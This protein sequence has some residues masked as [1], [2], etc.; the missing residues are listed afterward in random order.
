[1]RVPSSDNRSAVVSDFCPKKHRRQVHFFFFFAL[2]THA[3]AD[4]GD[5]GPFHSV[6]WSVDWSHCPANA[7]A[8]DITGSSHW[9]DTLWSTLREFVEVPFGKRTC[10]HAHTP[11]MLRD[12]VC[13]C[14]R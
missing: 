13:V 1:M 10:A 2:A 5:R 14:A 3:G 12:Q 4:S 8:V 6:D 9:P 11:R 7:P